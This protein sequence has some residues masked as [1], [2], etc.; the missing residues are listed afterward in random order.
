MC[1][2]STCPLMSM[3]SENPYTDITR[4]IAKMVGKAFPIEQNIVSLDLSCYEQA[5]KDFVI[6]EN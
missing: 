1:V 5:A 2:R 4:K 3:E 6:F